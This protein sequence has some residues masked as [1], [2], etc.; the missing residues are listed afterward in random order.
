MPVG[1]QN[2]AAASEKTKDPGLHKGNAG[3]QTLD[4]GLL[5]KRV[6][7]YGCYMFLSVLL[8]V[9]FMSPGSQEHLKEIE[10]CGLP[11]GENWL[12]ISSGACGSVSSFAALLF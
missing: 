6:D 9:P 7:S 5:P 4:S 1:I 12:S 11:F 2:A 3:S 8:L 10:R